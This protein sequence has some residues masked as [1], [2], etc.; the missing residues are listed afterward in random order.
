MTDK[1]IMLAGISGALLLLVML[2]G[3]FFI[4]PTI[5]SASSGQ[6][7]TATPSATAKT[8]YCAQYEQNLAKKLNVSVTTLTQDK[9]STLID[10]IN[11]KVKDGKL[12]QAKATILIQRINKS[13]GNACPKQLA[14]ANR[15]AWLTTHSQDVINQLAQGL[16]LNA[17]QLQAQFKAG[18][19]LQ[20]IAKTQN[21]STSALQTLVKNTATTIVKNA[22]TSGKLT[23]TRADALTK[24]IQNH[25]ALL[26]RWEA[27]IVKKASTK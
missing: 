3:I 12:T 1:T 18:K 21:V 17:S 26:Q 27:A 8:G 24:K 19:N 6:A 16:H 9:K 5:A 11:Q 13:T 7:A 23:Q 22:V 14:N 15:H 10:T 25:P 2:V 4:A 20:E